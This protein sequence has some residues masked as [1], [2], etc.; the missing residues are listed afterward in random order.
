[1]FRELKIDRNIAAAGAE[2]LTIGMQNVN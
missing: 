1:M 2:M